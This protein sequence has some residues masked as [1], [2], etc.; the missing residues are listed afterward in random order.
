MT[1]SATR[2]ATPDPGK[3]DEDSAGPFRPSVPSGGVTMEQS[4]WS[5]QPPDQPDSFTS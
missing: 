5:Q 1:A 4:A 2:A 3:Y